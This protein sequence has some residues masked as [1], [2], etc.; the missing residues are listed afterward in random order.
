M[1]FHFSDLLHQNPESRR[2]QFF[3]NFQIFLKILPLFLS[4]FRLKFFQ[5]GKIQKLCFCREVYILK[6][7]VFHPCIKH[8][9]VQK[10]KEVVIKKDSSRLSKRYFSVTTGSISSIRNSVG[11]RTLEEETSSQ[12]SMLVMIASKLCQSKIYEEVLLKRFMSSIEMCFSLLSSLISLIRLQTS[13]LSAKNR[14]NSLFNYLVFCTKIWTT[15]M[16]EFFLF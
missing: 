2:Y 8:L 1:K 10:F 6:K 13:K 4:Y 14:F 5:Q 12:K 7:T 16:H 15:L 11:S 9:V 3:F